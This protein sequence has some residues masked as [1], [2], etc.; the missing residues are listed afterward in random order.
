MSDAAHN[1]RLPWAQRRPAPRQPPS[2]GALL[3][4]RG[5]LL[6]VSLAAILVPAT[7]SAAA[8]LPE[9]ALGESQRVPSWIYAYID[10][11]QRNPR[12]TQPSTLLPHSQY[13][14]M[15]ASMRRWSPR[16]RLIEGARI[17]DRL[18]EINPRWTRTLPRTGVAYF[19]HHVCYTD[20][21]ASGAWLMNRLPGADLR[22]MPLLRRAIALVPKTCRVTTPA[23]LDH[24][25]NTIVGRV[26]LNQAAK[27]V[28]LPQQATSSGSS[29]EE[30][31][32]KG[33]C[34][35]LRRLSG[36]HLQL[37][38]NAFGRWVVTK[39]RSRRGGGVF[40]SIT[41]SA[42][43]TACPRLLGSLLRRAGYDVH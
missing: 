24:A 41:T 22:A 2:A 15:L 25:S 3:L 9:S 5:V 8:S 40:L 18:V 20:S 14:A 42:G 43:W 33:V 29:L 26:L 10:A 1:G 38:V 11:I 17:F 36:R 6:C 19:A 12:H 37:Q 34:T 30:A 31:V 27:P 39:F 23:A 28:E 13:A 16:G 21:R 35:G 32:N 4:C 7:A